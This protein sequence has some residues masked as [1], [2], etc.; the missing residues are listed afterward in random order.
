M[1][2]IHKS[3]GKKLH[4]IYNRMFNRLPTTNQKPDNVI[5]FASQK[6]FYIFDAKYRIQFDKD[7][8]KRYGKPGPMEEDINTMHRYRDAIA[9]PHP[10]T[11]QYQRG[12]VIGAAVLF[13]HPDE[14]EYYGHHFHKSIDQ[15]EIGGLPLMPNATSMLASKLEQLLSNEYFFE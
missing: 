13:P 3:S 2:F 4:V 1:Q 9:I 8:L 5:Q 7:Y 11:Q 15:V 12:V 14:E 10:M 6:R